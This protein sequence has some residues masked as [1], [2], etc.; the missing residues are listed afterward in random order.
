MA[1]ELTF[2]DDEGFPTT[3]LELG[4]AD[5]DALMI[6]AERLKLRQLCRFHD[7]W[8]DVEL[9]APELRSLLEELDQL[10]TSVEIGRPIRL[11]ARRVRTIAEAALAAGKPFLALAD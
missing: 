1:L 5:H 3:G 10:E 9:A 2:L 8:N 7:Y 6:A 11:I 4:M